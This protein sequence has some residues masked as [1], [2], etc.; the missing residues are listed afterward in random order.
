MRN[1]R[2]KSLQIAVLFLVPTFIIPNAQ[3]GETIIQQEKIAFEKCLKV[4]TVSEKKLS[5][6]PEI[7]DIS[8]QKRLALFTLSDGTLTITCDGVKG[9][10]TVSTNTN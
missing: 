1:R 7:E 9:N 5:I 2:I 10:I 6:A 8:D 3:A 4:I